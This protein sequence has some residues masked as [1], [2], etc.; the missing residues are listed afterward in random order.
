MI[1]ISERPATDQERKSVYV[2]TESN[3]AGFIGCKLMVLVVGAIG[4]YSYFQ[5]GPR[6]L[7]F[8]I[9]GISAF[10]LLVS[11]WWSLVS[12]KT[13]RLWNSGSGGFSVIRIEMPVQEAWKVEFTESELDRNRNL[14]ASERHGCKWLMNIAPGRYALLDRV[15]IDRSPY[16]QNFVPR[17]RLVAEWVRPSRGGWKALS[18]SSVGEL[19]PVSP[20][21]KTED[22]PNGTY[23]LNGIWPTG[24]AKQG[25]RLIA[26]LRLGFFD[27]VEIHDPDAPPPGPSRGSDAPKSRRSPY[28]T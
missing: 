28:E 26:D 11:T 16:S 19:I 3:V 9:M 6:M 4:V 7:A 12:L 2:R 22:L 17:E 21:M 15:E 5:V 13:R 27:D 10:G 8:V 25:E 14:P 1:Q 23:T 18:V 20:T 24:D